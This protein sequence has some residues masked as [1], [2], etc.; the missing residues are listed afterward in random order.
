MKALRIMALTG[1]LASMVISGCD[2]GETDNP[3][4]TTDPDAAPQADGGDAAV[5]PD[6]GDAGEEGPDGGDASVDAGLTF[7]TFVRD[8]LDNPENSIPVE[9]PNPDL[10]DN[11]NP[12]EYDDLFP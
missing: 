8:V 5:L 10:P 12:A 6:G 2:C 9:L 3:D 1:L 7:P 11:E 4:A